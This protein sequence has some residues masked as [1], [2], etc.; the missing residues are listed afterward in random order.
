VLGEFKTPIKD[1]GILTADFDNPEA[2]AYSYFIR[3]G[4][5]SNVDFTK[6][7]FSTELVTLHPTPQA[8][9]IQDAADSGGGKQKLV[10]GGTEMG[11]SSMTL[12]PSPWLQLAVW[13]FISSLKNVMD[14]N[15]PMKLGHRVVCSWA[16]HL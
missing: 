4:Q 1:G 16:L 11:M 5:D 14:S 2:S 13:K 3:A 10:E 12:A 6:M 8:T 9:I 7:L 15:L